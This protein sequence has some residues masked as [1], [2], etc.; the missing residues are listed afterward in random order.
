MS[1]ASNLTEQQWQEVE[2]RAGAGESKRALAREFGVSDSALRE[3][4]VRR[5]V[6]LAPAAAEQAE[7]G[8]TVVERAPAGHTLARPQPDP[9]IAPTGAVE[10]H[11]APG[12]SAIDSAVELLRLATAAAGGGR[13]GDLAGQRS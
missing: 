1:R 11:L 7:Q 9:D 6:P 3:M 10:R 5:A 13:A 12:A 4:L 2:R 8:P